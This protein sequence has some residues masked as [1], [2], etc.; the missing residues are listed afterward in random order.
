M[1]VTAIFPHFSPAIFVPRSAMID[2][3]WRASGPDTGTGTHLS[4]VSGAKPRNDAGST[5]A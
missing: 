4:H 1:L 2:A 5:I 3:A